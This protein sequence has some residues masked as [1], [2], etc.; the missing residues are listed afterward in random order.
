MLLN[1]GPNFISLDQLETRITNQLR[2]EGSAVYELPYSFDLANLFVKSR[3]KGYRLII[4]YLK[5]KCKLE[6]RK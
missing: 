1:T 3:G 6:K 5:G 2:K 4:M